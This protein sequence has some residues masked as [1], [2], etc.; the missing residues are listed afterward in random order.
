[1]TPF[2]LARLYKTN[3]LRRRPL[4][5]EKKNRQIDYFNSYEKII[6]LLLTYT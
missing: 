3:L 4:S 5:P 2:A 1:M 6:V